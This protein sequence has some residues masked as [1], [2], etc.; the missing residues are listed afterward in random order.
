MPYFT[1]N[2]GK[3]QQG[4]LPECTNTQIQSKEL[5]SEPHACL[6]LKGKNRILGTIQKDLDTEEGFENSGLR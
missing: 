4:H 3:A 6:A 5:G 2:L 1:D